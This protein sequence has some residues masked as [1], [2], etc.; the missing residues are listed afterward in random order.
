M[1]APGDITDE[2]VV[3]P[4]TVAD[5]APLIEL[6]QQVWP[7]RR[8]IGPHVDRRWWWRFPEPPLVV[9]ADR[10]SGHLAGLCAYMPFTLHSSSMLAPLSMRPVEIAFT[11]IRCFAYSTAIERVSAFMAPLVAV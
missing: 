2:F 6:L 10:Q 9:I 8:P 1:P 4:Y 3:R 7:N 5:R 11:R